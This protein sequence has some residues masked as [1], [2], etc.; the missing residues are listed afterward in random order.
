ML[1]YEPLGLF[2]KITGFIRIQNGRLLFHIDQKL[3]AAFQKKTD[4]V[5][6]G[7]FFYKK[8]FVLAEFNC[9]IIKMDE[10][11]TKEKLA[12]ADIKHQSSQQHQSISGFSLKKPLFHSSRDFL[13]DDNL[14]VISESGFSD[15]SHYTDSIGHGSPTALKKNFSCADM[16]SYQKSHQKL[17]S[18][19]LW[20]WL[21]TQ[22][23]H[24]LPS[25]KEN[26]NN[27][28]VTDSSSLKNSLGV[29]GC[30]PKRKMFWRDINVCSPSGF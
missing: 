10:S 4:T 5:S 14:S 22:M 17:P 11:R 12:A 30:A 6:L 28:N 9:R 13:D 19:M 16:E 15:A 7:V 21:S 25:V 26:Q 3:N 24:P 18:S 27:L 23:Q 2:T 1:K 8:L 29:M 20:G